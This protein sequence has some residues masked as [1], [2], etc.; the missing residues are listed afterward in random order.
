MVQ[1]H[2]Q[3]ED[4]IQKNIHRLPAYN[5]LEGEII[6]SFKLSNIIEHIKLLRVDDVLELIY[7]Y[8]KNN[9]EKFTHK[10]ISQ[11]EK[12]DDKIKI[13]I[14]LLISYSNA[15]I[16]SRHVI[17]EYVL[18]CSRYL[19]ETTIGDIYQNIDDEV[20]TTNKSE[21]VSMLEYKEF[22]F[23]RVSVGE[24]VESRNTNI[25][26]NNDSIL[27]DRITVNNIVVDI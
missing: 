26:D 6:V 3:I 14:N 25:D 24:I 16:S 22:Q 23:L 12:F 11:L 10:F 8:N 27:F 20:T 19:S 4:I 1:T 17:L 2:Q 13:M 15:S 7:E 18:A 21:I 5:F 9:E